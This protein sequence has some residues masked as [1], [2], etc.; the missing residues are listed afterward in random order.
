MNK[1]PDTGYIKLDTG[2]IKFDD[3]Y[4]YLQFYLPF[5]LKIKYKLGIKTFFIQYCLHNRKT[6]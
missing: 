5:Q 1:D 3:V 6:S 2:Y 4:L